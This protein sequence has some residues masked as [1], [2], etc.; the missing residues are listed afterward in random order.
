MLETALP[1][2]VALLLFGSMLSLPH[3]QRPAAGVAVAF[4]LLLLEPARDAEGVRLAGPST[5]LA[6][7]IFLGVALTVFSGGWRHLHHP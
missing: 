2:V 3:R 1:Y 6:L 7:L 4:I 5:G